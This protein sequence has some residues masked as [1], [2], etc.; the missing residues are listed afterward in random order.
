M[1]EGRGS[2]VG[3]REGHVVED[4]RRLLAGG[5]ERAV[6]H[7]A[8]RVEDLVD[9]G[10]AG[11]RLGFLDD[12]VGEL[13]ALHQDLGT[14]V[15]E[16]NELALRE[17][18]DVDLEAADV[19]RD[20]E[21]EVADGVGE[22]AQRPGDIAHVHLL[23]AEVAGR[24]V[25]AGDLVCLA[26]EG[27]YHADALEVLRCTQQDVV[28]AALHG[29]VQPGRD[30]HHQGDHGE[31]DH[32]GQRVD[33]PLGTVDGKDEHERA[34]HHKG[35]AQDEAEEHVDAVLHLLCVVGHARD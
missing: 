31:D 15:D 9:A 13:D 32:D 25:H 35:G 4:D 11:G 21:P 28:Q 14:V 19:E 8:L 34:A 17:A 12:E 30:A 16:S 3:I 23:A 27:A 29:A 1:R 26:A 20:C 6:P 24:L 18:A 22:R 33:Q 10:G 7:G 5:V 2:T